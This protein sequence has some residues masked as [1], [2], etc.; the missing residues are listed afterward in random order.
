MFACVAY[1]REHRLHIVLLG[2]VCS[3]MATKEAALGEFDLVMATEHQWL[4]EFDETHTRPIDRLLAQGF[5]GWHEGTGMAFS[6]QDHRHTR[7]VL[8]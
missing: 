8:P 1:R 5:S 7:R 3:D 4:H 2:R 6:L